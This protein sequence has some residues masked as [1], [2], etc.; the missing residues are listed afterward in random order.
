MKDKNINHE[1]NGIVSEM[2][3][4]SD[5]WLAAGKAP[6]DSIDDGMLAIDSQAAYGSS[7][8]LYEKYRPRRWEDVIG[9]EKAIRKIHTLKKR[10]LGGRAYWISGQSGTGK[11]TIA[12]LLAEEIADR[13]YIEEI[14]ASKLTP[15][16]LDEVVNTFHYSAWGKGGHAL[17]A[18]EAHGLRKDTI[19][20]LLVYLEPLPRHSMMVF[21]TTC[22]GQSD[23]FEDQIDANP[24]LSRCVRIELSRRNLTES[25][26]EYAK[27]IAQAENLDGKPLEQYI[28]LAKN[29]RNNLR[30]ILQAVETGEMLV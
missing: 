10:G 29:H 13:F 27:Q 28:R 2:L 7:P 6:P 20:Q 26:A 22:E 4:N 3:E 1:E 16:K 11:T 8:P 15:S 14:D 9:Q 12:R 30:A 17:I 24:L 18:N 5:G 21:T 19:R 23:F 25:F